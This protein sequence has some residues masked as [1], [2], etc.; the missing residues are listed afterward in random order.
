MWD[1]TRAVHVTKTRPKTQTEIKNTEYP[2]PG[3]YTQ[4]GRTAWERGNNVAAGIASRYKT[5][6]RLETYR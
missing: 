1:R 5:G 4:G 2:I 6:L 3:A